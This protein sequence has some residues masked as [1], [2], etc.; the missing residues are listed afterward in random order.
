M[1]VTGEDLAFADNS[2]AINTYGAGT[3]FNIFKD[4]KIWVGLDI[5][6]GPEDWAWYV[7]V[8]HPW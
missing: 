1:G 7:Q 2:E 3:R 5:A 6:R 8:N 4:Q